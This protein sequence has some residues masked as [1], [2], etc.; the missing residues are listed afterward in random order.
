MSHDPVNL[1]AAPA[2]APL[3]LPATLLITD[4]RSVA[5]DLREAVLR[6]DVSIDASRLKDVDTSGLQLLL[7]TRLATLAAGHEFRWTADSD[8]L[9][10]AA[11]A[12]GLSQS[13]GLA[14]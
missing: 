4:A 13:L 12:T 10:T 8:G 7:A 5:A 14:A 11:A 2:G 6:G 9:R 1:G 3:V